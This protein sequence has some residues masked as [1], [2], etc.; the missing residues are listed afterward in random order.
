MSRRDHRLRTCE[1]QVDGEVDDL[2]LGELET[3]VEP[4][5]DDLEEERL[6]VGGAVHLKVLAVVVAI[7]EDAILSQGRGKVGGKVEA[8]IKVVE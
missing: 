2:V 4:A 5:F 1:D 8:R 7:V 3:T 6:T